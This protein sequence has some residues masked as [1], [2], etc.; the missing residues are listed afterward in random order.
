[1]TEKRQKGGL[2][3]PIPGRP[4]PPSAV[5]EDLYSPE[6]LITEEQVVGWLAVDKTWLADHRTRVEPIIPHVKLGKTIRYSR[7]AIQYWLSECVQTTPRWERAS[8]AV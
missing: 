1:M 3:K 5:N 4:E 7:R 6:D 8:S 2:L